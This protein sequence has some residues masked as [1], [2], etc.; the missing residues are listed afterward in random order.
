MRVAKVVGQFARGEVRDVVLAG[1]GRAVQPGEVAHAIG[2]GMIR[3]R[4]VSAH[5]QPTDHLPIRIEWDATAES[6]DATGHAANSRSLRLEFRIER[7]GIVQPVERASREAA[8]RRA[9]ICGL[10]KRVKIGG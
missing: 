4:R 1:L 10:R 7:I 2:N 8:G 9:G 6:D 3:A 5:P